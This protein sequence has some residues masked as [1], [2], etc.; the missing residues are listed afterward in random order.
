MTSLEQRDQIRQM[1]NQGFTSPAIAQALGVSVH[2]IRK[3]RRILKKRIPYTLPWVAP[4]RV[5]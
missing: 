1:V 4:E 3:W 2:T 5:R